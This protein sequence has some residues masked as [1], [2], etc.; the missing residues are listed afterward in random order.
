MKA[1]ECDLAFHV[2]WKAQ[3]YRP[4]EIKVFA[5]NAIHCMARGV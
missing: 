1:N 3:V 2:G 5:A 4:S